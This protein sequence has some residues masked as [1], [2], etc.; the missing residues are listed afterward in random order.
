MEKHKREKAMHAFQAESTDRGEMDRILSKIQTSGLSSL[1]KS[2]R[3]FLE[4]RSEQLRK[5]DR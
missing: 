3:G 2:E 4:R 5:E 1:S